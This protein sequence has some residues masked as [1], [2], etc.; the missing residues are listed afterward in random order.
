AVSRAR[1]ASFT[2]SELMRSS[3]SSRRWCASLRRF[4]AKEFVSISSAPA[5]TKPTWSET[6]ASGARRFASSAHLNRGTAAEISAPMPPSA[7]IG[8]PAES[9]SRKRLTGE[10]KQSTEDEGWEEQRHAAILGLHP[11]S[12][13]DAAGEAPENSPQ[14]EARAALAAGPL[15]QDRKSVV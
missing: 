10:V 15:R 7:T 6:T 5:F 9:L 12:V 1:R 4:A 3:S 8:G 11:L 2:D 13:P 14:G